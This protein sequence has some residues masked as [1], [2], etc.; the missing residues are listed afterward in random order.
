VAMVW[1]AGG[2][3]DTWWDQNPIFIHG[4]NMLPF[5]GGSLYLGRHPDLCKSNFE[6]VMERAGGDT[7][8]WRD[9]MEMYEAF[10]DSKKALAMWD[11][12]HETDPEYGNSRAQIYSWLTSLDE[13]GHVDA[14]VWADVPTYAVFK[15][16]NVRTYIAYNGTDKPLT[17]TFSDGQTLKVPP[18][19]L[20]RNTRSLAANAK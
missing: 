7:Y 3:Y 2:K 5:N 15:K 10:F 6:S 20:M 13:F 1:G 16:G 17:A 19:Q 14:S 11:E 4:I 18:N 8:I 9:Y 12:E